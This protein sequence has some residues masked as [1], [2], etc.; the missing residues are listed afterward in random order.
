MKVLKLRSVGI[1]GSLR[2]G[3]LSASI[4]DVQ[5]DVQVQYSHTNNGRFRASTSATSVSESLYPRRRLPSRC[6]AKS[7]GATRDCPSAERV[8]TTPRASKPDWSRQRHADVHLHQSF[9]AAERRNTLRALCLLHRLPVSV[10][11]TRALTYKESWR[12]LKHQASR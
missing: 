9:L 11:A 2:R 8:T 4:S 1:L 10:F 5:E 12:Y 7:G 3:A 6:G